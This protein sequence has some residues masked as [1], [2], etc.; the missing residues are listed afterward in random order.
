MRPED[1]PVKKSRLR[2][3]IITRQMV[4]M[5]PAF[6][7]AALVVNSQ[8]L[9]VPADG[10]TNAAIWYEEAIRHLQEPS[11]EVAQKVKAIIEEGWK[12][13][14][15]AASEY[16]M[17]NNEAYSLFQRAARLARCDFWKGMNIR[18]VKLLDV[19]LPYPGKGLTQLAQLA[20]LE[21]RRQEALA[22]PA[23]AL[24]NYLLVI[25]LGHHLGQEPNPTLLGKLLEVIVQGLAYR[26]LRELVKGPSLGAADLRT[27]I[28]T[29]ESLKDGWVG[30]DRAL[31][32]EPPCGDIRRS[33]LAERIQAD[34]MAKAG[35]F[36]EDMKKTLQLALDHI[37]KSDVVLCEMAK[38]AA[39]TNAPDEYDAYIETVATRARDAVKPYRVVGDWAAQV[40]KMLLGTIS[41]KKLS[42]ETRSTVVANLL[43]AITPPKLGKIVARYYA[44]R[45]RFELLLIGSVVRLYELERGTRPV[46][47]E[48]LVPL[49]LARIPNDPF[50]PVSAVRYTQEDGA[51]RLYSVGPD[52][53]DQQGLQEVAQK[54]LSGPGD[55]VF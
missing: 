17:R 42:I 40:P 35:R 54:E 19:E 9:A 27:A 15:P 24:D 47:L 1:R 52:R 32:V 31:D 18:D 37:H 39:R 16:L 33:G 53:N 25:R 50:K 21:G 8:A 11:G 38:D 22:A 36:D 49:Y 48:E 45:A 12:Q 30:L 44:N 5:L 28:T 6:F 7:T 51:W 23:L 26:P 10:E 2:L 43:M 14:E 34:V 13:D 55:I 4:K 46:D 3:R 29:L 20:L 41:P